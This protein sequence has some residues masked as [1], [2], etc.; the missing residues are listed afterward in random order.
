M[1]GTYPAYLALHDDDELARRALVAV[2]SL[3]S[4][5][6]CA[7]HCHADRLGPKPASY[8]RTGRYAQVSSCFPHLG[9][10][11]CLRGWNGS[12]TIF[13]THCNLGCVF[14]Q[15]YDISHEGQGRE[16]T[17]RELAAMM[18]SLQRQ[19]C[20][21]INFVTPSHVVP[22]ILEALVIAVEN[23]LQIPL[24]YNT[25]GYDSLDT[26]RLLDGVVDIYM[27]DFKFWDSMIAEEL[28]HAADY[29]E[30]ARAALREMHRQVGDL[31]IDE[32][33]L[34]RRGVLVRHLVMP[35]D[36][37]GTREIMKFLA[38]EI[39]PDTY[40]NVMAQYQPAGTARQHP[41]I[42]RNTTLEEY[43]DALQIARE[44]G[45]HRLDVR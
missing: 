23:G 12:G 10:E 8:C 9:E 42:A 20:H 41:D 30:V 13:F 6:G 38:E 44:A 22:Q 33:G 25:G 19:G 18:L 17:P 36:Q 21:N 35:N 4:C 32:E 3:A 11:N 15:N 40:V 34:A 24:I 31:E 37:A 39:S 1:L 27:P 43:H 2:E 16:V 28:T 14:C 29:P 26:L 7:R 5:I 45:I